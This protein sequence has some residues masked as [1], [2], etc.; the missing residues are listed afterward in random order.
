[1]AC[2]FEDQI[3]LGV[4]RRTRNTFFFTSPLTSSQ[5]FKC[6]GLCAPR[7]SPARSPCLSRALPVPLLS[8]LGQEDYSRV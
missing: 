3:E 1:M 4:Y 6:I 7:A 5:V 8:Q 2:S